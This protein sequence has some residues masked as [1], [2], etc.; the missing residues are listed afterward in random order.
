MREGGWLS[1]AAFCQRQLA[2]A[3]GLEVHYHAKLQ[4]LAYRNGGWTLSLDSGHTLNAEA[5]VLTRG[6]LQTESEAESVAALRPQAGQVTLVNT[7]TLGHTLNRPFSQQRHYGI[8]LSEGRVLCGAQNYR[9]VAKAPE[10]ALDRLNLRA[11]GAHFG[12]EHPNENA[13]ID[14]R[15]ATR[16]TTPDHLPVVGGVPDSTFFSDAYAQLHHGRR[17]DTFPTAR[18][19]PGLYLING[20]GSH[21]ILASPLLGK[22]LVDVMTGKVN[23]EHRNV[24]QLL[25]PGRF[26]LRQLRR[27]PTDRKA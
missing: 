11:L 20:L 14:G 5:V 18:Y 24:L 7:H 6:Y 8:P 2:R 16:A 1:P 27:K 10:R 22:L 21:G 13:I 9:A 25:H 23:D 26:I 17:G 12:Q 3:S 19:L 4:S 15:A